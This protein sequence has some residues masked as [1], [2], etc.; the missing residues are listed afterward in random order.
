MARNISTVMIAA[1]AS[2]VWSAL[3]DP[4]LV[5]KWQYGS[6]LSTEWNVESPICFKTEWQGQVFEQW[7]TVLEFCPFQTLRYSLFAP[8]P[9]LADKPENYFE[10]EYVLTERPAGTLLEI[11][12]IDNRDGAVQEAPQ[13]E[14]SNP[15]LTTLKSVVEVSWRT[16]ESG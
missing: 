10:M 8:R 5:S 4:L 13:D 15:V 11:V 7:G 1:R 2:R 3:T 6:V 12:Q 9:G 14:K 16:K